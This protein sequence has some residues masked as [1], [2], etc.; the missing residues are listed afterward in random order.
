MFFVWLSIIDSLFFLEKKSLSS[1]S[2]TSDLIRSFS[3]S[4]SAWSYLICFLPIIYSRLI[5][6][7]EW[8]WFKSIFSSLAF[9]SSSCAY[10][11]V[12]TANVSSTSY[13]SRILLFSYFSYRF[14]N[15]ARRYIYDF[16][17][18]Y[19]KNLWASAGVLISVTFSKAYKAAVF[20]MDSL[21]TNARSEKINWSLEWRVKNITYSLF[22]WP[23]ALNIRFE[24]P[25]DPWDWK[26]FLLCV[27]KLEFC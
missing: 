2:S 19:W 23:D 16:K 10:W 20:L 18:M 6:I 27:S 21:H 3:L 8:D 4:F 11:V 17:D 13:K 25:D 1:F 9:F 14:A 26:D 12:A 7:S 24:D 22:T 5:P 15:W